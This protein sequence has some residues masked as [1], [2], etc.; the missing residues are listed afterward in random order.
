MMRAK[1]I[2]VRVS[3]SCVRRTP[4]GSRLSASAYGSKPDGRRSGTGGGMRVYGSELARGR[5]S[6]QTAGTR[7]P[8][9]L[10]STPQR[11]TSMPNYPDAHIA[12]HRFRTVDERARVPD[13]FR[14]RHHLD[15]ELRSVVRKAHDLACLT[16]GCER[17]DEA[18]FAKRQLIDSMGR[19]YESLAEL[20]RLS[21]PAL[22][23]LYAPSEAAGWS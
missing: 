21:L 16:T 3:I 4:R 5:D 19:D 20:N 9:D 2:A 18:L 10:S 8:V 13:A 7:V 12:W 23:G 11:S 15:V 22:F 1:T 14:M 17:L 6:A